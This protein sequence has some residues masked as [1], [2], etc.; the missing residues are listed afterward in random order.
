MKFK[1]AAEAYE[2]LGNEEK[3]KAYDEELRYGFGGANTGSTQ[4]SG[5]GSGGISEEDLFGMFF[6]SRGAADRAGFD[7]FSGSGGVRQGGEDRGVKRRAPCRLSW[8]LR[9]SRLIR[10]GK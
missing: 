10:A 9:W 2:V 3:R 6:G 5:S 8:R 7:F 1:E 4:H